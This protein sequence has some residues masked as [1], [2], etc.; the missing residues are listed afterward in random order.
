MMET[1]TMEEQLDLQSE[2]ARAVAPED[3][4]KGDYICVLREIYE[5][6]AC[7]DAV[8]TWHAPKIVRVAMTPCRTSA[9]RKIVRI[10]LPLV[11]AREPSG[12]LTTL[13]V[14]RFELARLPDRSGRAMYKQLRK[15]HRE[16]T[17]AP[18]KAAVEK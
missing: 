2:L 17:E 6:L 4:R 11:L 13:D 16:K 7:I 15:K 5:L 10:S 1:R 14:R 9:P 8:E 18:A 3:L 12:D